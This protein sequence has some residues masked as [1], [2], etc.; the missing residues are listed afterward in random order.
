MCV[1]ALS[2]SPISGRKGE[3]SPSDGPS[4]GSIKALT[5]SMFVSVRVVH[6]WP[7]RGQNN[8]WELCY[9]P[10]IRCTRCPCWPFP[11]FFLSLL[12]FGGQPLHPYPTPKQPVSGD[13]TGVRPAYCV[14]QPGKLSS[15]GN[16]SNTILPSVSSVCSELLG[17]LPPRGLGL[18]RGRRG[19]LF[20]AD[21][22]AACTCLCAGAHFS[23]HLPR[24]SRLTFSLVG[25]EA[26]GFLGHQRQSPE[27][28]L[29]LELF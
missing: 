24:I 18:G 11:Q 19:G 10:A 15:F 7:S 1:M 12:S 29:P 21:Q 16:W 27:T 3:V 8:N 26:A 13:N 17:R 4:P 14:A 22:D 20:F 9:Y 5:G 6:G 23:T 2:S 25:H 28:N